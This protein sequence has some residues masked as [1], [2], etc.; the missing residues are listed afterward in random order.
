MGP[1]EQSIACA[2]TYP[3]SPSPLCTSQ[4]YS[5]GPRTRNT[6]CEQGFKLYWDRLSNLEHSLLPTSKWTGLA[7]RSSMGTVF[8]VSTF[9]S[10][11]QNVS[12]E[13]LLGCFSSV[14]LRCSL[15]GFRSY[16][17][18]QPLYFQP[19]LVQYMTHDKKTSTKTDRLSFAGKKRISGV[20]I[21]KLL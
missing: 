2:K 17:Q 10:V 21:L 7:Q 9:L 13:F 12:M 15:R 4:A 16:D 18:K 3:L 19:L 14:G 1:H 8:L 11:P 5:I 6:Y 20:V